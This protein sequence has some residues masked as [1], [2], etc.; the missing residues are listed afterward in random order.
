MKIANALKLAD[1]RPMFR[2]VTPIAKIGESPNH[3][4]S[5]KW[6]RIRAANGT[7]KNDA[8]DFRTEIMTAVRQN[9]VLKLAIDVSETTSDRKA[10]AGWSEIGEIRI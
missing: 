5:P 7:V 8:A 6:I 9:K 1:K 2:P 10:S 4:R 3:V